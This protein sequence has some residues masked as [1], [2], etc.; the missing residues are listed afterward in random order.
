[1]SFKTILWF[2]S[3]FSYTS[4]SVVNFRTLQHSTLV[5]TSHPLHWVS[6]PLT[7]TNLFWLWGASP[8]PPPPRPPILDMNVSSMWL[9]WWAGFFHVIKMNLTLLSILQ[10]LIPFIVWIDTPHVYSTVLIGFYLFVLFFWSILHKLGFTIYLPLPSTPIFFLFFFFFG[11]NHYVR[12]SHCERPHLC[13]GGSG[14]HEP[15]SIPPPFLQLPS[16]ADVL[17]PVK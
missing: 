4:V 7:T 2:V 15:E 16:P 10:G 1:M 5:L 9:L 6:Q 3:I 8:R 14:N 17:W 12:L 11:M 13:T